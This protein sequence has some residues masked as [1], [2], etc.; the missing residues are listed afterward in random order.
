MSGHKILTVVGAR[1]QFIKAATVSR[2]IS[3]CDGLF[4]TLVHTGQHFGDTMSDIFFSELN[5][6]VPAYS[7]GICGGGHGTMTGRMM[8][9]L[10]AVMLR[11][12]PAAVLVYGDTN[13]TLAAAVT[14][15]K[16]AI[17]VA[18]VEAG[19]RSFRAM[20][21]EINRILADRVSRWLFCPTSTAVANLAS[22]GLTAGVHLVGDVMYDLALA[23]RSYP[24]KRSGTLAR[25]NLRPDAFQL[26]TLHRAENTD[27]QA[28]LARALAYLNDEARDT[29]I[30]L[31][32]HPRTRSAAERF[33]LGFG[34][35]RVAEP[36]GYLEML[37]LLAGCTRVLTDS[38][39]L[40]KEAY[41]FRK[42]C[43]TLRDATEWGETI[44]A[45]WNRLW[46]TPDYAPRHEIASFG[47]GHA[48][49]KIVSILLLDM[50]RSA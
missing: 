16:L 13:T 28:A 22:E 45:G 18:H 3:A 42:P 32:L 40:Q 10:E 8:I 26:A 15:A 29:P 24:A 20:P 21:E 25:F 23:L 30:L 34:S 38:G 48:A 12:R 35:L 50:R 46:T 43:V 31:L 7:L 41:F 47:D 5:L 37:T 6:A 36:V 4:E 2:A 49:E 11:E 1:P 33:G 39:G 9:A 27:E 44:K 14:A 17:P 19:L